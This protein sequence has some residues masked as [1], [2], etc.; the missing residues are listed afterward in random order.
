ML[1]HSQIIYVNLQI[2]WWYLET[3][4]QHIMSIEYLSLR[5]DMKWP[6]GTVW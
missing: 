1:R 5:H 6:P 2:L 4:I 3:K